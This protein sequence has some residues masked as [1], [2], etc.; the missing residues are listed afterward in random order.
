[1]RVDVGVPAGATLTATAA[2]TFTNC[3]GGLGPTSSD[4][5][6]VLVGLQGKELYLVPGS[7]RGLTPVPPTGTSGQATYRVNRGGSSF[8]FDLTAPLARDF[9]ALSVIASLYLDSIELRDGFGPT[10]V[11]SRM[12]A[13]VARVSISDPFGSGEIAGA[14]WNLTD[15]ADS[16]VL[17]FAPMT[18]IATD[19]ASPSASKQF[20]SSYGPQLT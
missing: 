15:P 11:W 9:R 4:S 13:L 1:T 6:S 12:D 14:W 8:E 2:L 20:Q 19:P 5:T 18:S 16:I 3:T 7:L 17:T 10:T